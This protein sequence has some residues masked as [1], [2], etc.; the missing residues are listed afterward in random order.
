MSLTF[1]SNLTKMIDAGLGGE[2]IVPDTSVA[3]GYRMQYNLVSGPVASWNDPEGG[4]PINIAAEFGPIQAGTGDPSPEN[5]RPISGRTAVKVTRAGKNLL[6]DDYYDYSISSVYTYLNHVVPDG[7]TARFTFVDR[8]TSVE[9]PQNASIGFVSEDVGSE[10]PQ[11]FNWVYRSGSIQ[12]N[13]SNIVGTTK[14]Y[15]IFIYPKTKAVFDA[16]FARYDI[17]IELGATATAYEAPQIQSVEV[18][19]G[20]TVYGGRLDVSNGVLTVDRKFVTL[21][22]TENWNSFAAQ[23]GFLLGLDDMKVARANPGLASWLPTVDAVTQFGLMFGANNTVLY[24]GHITDNID[25]VST[26][27]TWKTYLGEHP[28]QIVYPLV[29]P[30]TVQLSPQIIT[31]L[32]GQNN[33]W[34]DAGD[35]AVTWKEKL[36]TE[37]Y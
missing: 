22:G 28:L 15:N 19:L 13:T 36:Y 29:Q 23:N 1:A 18:Q 4:L 2:L 8:D 12:S 20:Q 16:F 5:V 21:D 10:S 33:V 34:S 3:V 11:K 32:L 7:Q 26:V 9:I 17:Q 6:P 24:A 27:A 31:S 37:G 35:V 14:C 30:L 25:G